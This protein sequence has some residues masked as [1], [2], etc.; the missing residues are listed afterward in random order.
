MARQSKSTPASNPTTESVAGQISKMMESFKLPG[1][2]MTAL[3][4]SQ[5]KN[6]AAL[7]QATQIAT[8]GATAVSRRQAEIVQDAIKQAAAM[9]GNLNLSGSPEDVLAKRAELVRATFE[10]ALAN[11]RELAEMVGKANAEAFEVIKRRMS[12][13]FEEIRNTTLKPTLK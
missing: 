4:E 10:S 5:K 12:D 9:M 1:V 11:A 7:T 2:D 6:I 8:E 13:S 3:V